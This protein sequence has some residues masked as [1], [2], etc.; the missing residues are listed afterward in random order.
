MR[1]AMNS[2]LDDSSGDASVPNEIRVANP[3]RYMPQGEWGAVRPPAADAGGRLARRAGHVQGGR[4][5]EGGQGGPGA[6]GR[7]VGCHATGQAA[8]F[9]AMPVTFRYRFYIVRPMQRRFSHPLEWAEHANRTIRTKDLDNIVLFDGEPGN[10]K[11]TVALQLAYA[12]DPTFTNDRIHF[13]S[14]SDGIRGFL[15][16]AR[17][18]PP[19]SAILADEIR[20]HRRHSADG[21][22]KDLIDFLQVCRGL[23][24][25]I[26]MCFPHAGMMDRAVLDHRVRYKISAMEGY[27]AIISERI[28]Q[29]LPDRGGQ[30]MYV[31]RWPECSLPWQFKRNT[32]PIWE[33]YMVRK[34]AAAR[35]RDAKARGYNDPS[36]AEEDEWR[37]ILAEKGLRKGRRKGTT[38][39]I[40]D[41][42]L[43]PAL[44]PVVER[45][46]LRSNGHGR[47]PEFCGSK[48]LPCPT[49]IHNAADHEADQKRP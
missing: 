26:L 46:R 1:G 28:F 16:Q 27:R 48:L 12:L 5:H 10:G 40:K 2:L 8:V 45:A 31:V 30:E 17:Q 25:H 18:L 34:I 21:A 15:N 24:L 20:L 33:D 6:G 11:S 4:G 42:T 22:V 19:Y 29:A 36:E 47:H 43:P 14:P 44:K 49:G 35:E 39:P 23:N 13:E 9:K 3:P 7:V 38:R 37:N 32:G 41:D